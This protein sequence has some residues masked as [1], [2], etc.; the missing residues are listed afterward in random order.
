MRL[1]CC[2]VISRCKSA[3]SCKSISSVPIDSYFRSMLLLVWFLLLSYPWVQHLFVQPDLD[4][5]VQFHALQPFQ[6]ESSS[7]RISHRAIWARH[8][9]LHLDLSSQSSVS[10]EKSPAT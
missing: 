9:L 5:S 3:I 10:V 4:T 8:D 6:S 7:H 2:K 1:P